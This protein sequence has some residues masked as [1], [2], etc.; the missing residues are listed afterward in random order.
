MK[1]IVSGANGQLGKEFQFLSKNYSDIAFFFFGREELDITNEGKIKDLFA[2][3]NPDVFI[4]CAAY[5]AVDKAETDI[6][7]CFNINDYAVSLL[8]D[9]CAQ[10][11]CKMVHFSSDYVYHIEK[12]SPLIETDATLPRGIYAQTKLAGEQ[13]VL[14]TNCEYL[15]FRTSW[16]YSTFGKNFVKTVLRLA[17]TRESMSVVEDQ[18]GTLTYARD[19][20]KAVLEIINGKKEGWNQIYNYSNEGKSNWYQIASFITEYLSLPMKI[21]PIPSVE[22]PT[23]AERPYWSLMS[24]DKF[25]KTFGL[26]IPDWEESLRKSLDLIVKESG[27]LRE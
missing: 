2:Q 23:P 6:E 11:N 17:E 26:R 14:R 15:I 18:I 24:K 10:Q 1:I 20:A 21:N 7:H 5:T 9:I 3:I 8:A 12:D 22:Y 16:V 13:A 4:N 19:L 25:K 27:A